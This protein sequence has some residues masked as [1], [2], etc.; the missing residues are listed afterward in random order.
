M[1]GRYKGINRFLELLF[2]VVF[3]ILLPCGVVFIN[4]GTAIAVYETAVLA[5][6]FAAVAFAGNLP[7]V[8]S[9]DEKSLTINTAGVKRSF[10]IRDI[11][12]IEYKCSRGESVTVAVKLTVTVG[13]RKKRFLENARTGI[14]SRGRAPS[15][16]KLIQLCDYVNSVKDAWP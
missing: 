2:T 8:F 15:D 13:G 1:T 10:P 12:K 6:G 16:S 14:M 7:C 9:A 11:E 4:S 5:L 3:L